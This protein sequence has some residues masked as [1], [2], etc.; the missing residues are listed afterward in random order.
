M[1]QHPGLRIDTT[2]RA[3][4]FIGQEIV[5]ALAAWKQATVS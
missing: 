4:A 2:G 3:P 1:M 5:A